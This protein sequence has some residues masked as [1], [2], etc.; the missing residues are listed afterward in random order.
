MSVPDLSAFLESSALSAEQKKQVET[1]SDKNR[2]FSRILSLRQTHKAG[3]AIY[4]ARLFLRRSSIFITPDLVQQFQDALKMLSHAQ[5]ERHIHMEEGGSP[6]EGG[7]K[8]LETGE[9]VFAAL[10]S[11]VRS[12]AMRLSDASNG[13]PR[14]P[15][16]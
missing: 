5:V 14:D 4:D 13:S 3:V 6:R 10:Q 9:A 1:S 7:M 2:M 8:L 11:A 15:K 12:R 16:G